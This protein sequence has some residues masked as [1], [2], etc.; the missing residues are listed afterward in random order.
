MPVDIERRQQREW[1]NTT[2][3]EAAGCTDVMQDLL[4]VSNILLK[5]HTEKD[6]LKSQQRRLRWVLGNIPS[7][8]EW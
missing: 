4:K 5:I 7:Q 3:W 2:Q 6:G 1:L 8:K